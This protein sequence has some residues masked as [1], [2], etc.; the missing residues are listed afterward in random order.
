MS[1]TNSFKN[2]PHAERVYK[3]ELIQSVI[4]PSNTWVAHQA[5]ILAKNV[6]KVI[7]SS[8]VL[9]YTLWLLKGLGMS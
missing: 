6:V 1:I 3:R 9:K 7:D 2:T 8:L 4:W 5:E